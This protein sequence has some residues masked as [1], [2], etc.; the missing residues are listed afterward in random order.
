MK[1]TWTEN[2]KLSLLSLLLLAAVVSPSIATA[3]VDG[4]VDIQTEAL[5]HHEVSAEDLQFLSQLRRVLH[6]GE[7]AL[8]LMRDY[9]A[10]PRQEIEKATYEMLMTAIDP[11]RRYADPQDFISVEENQWGAILYQYSAGEDCGGEPMYEVVNRELRDSLPDSEETVLW[12]Q[13]MRFALSKLPRYEGLSFRGTRLS[14]ERIANYYRIGE[15]AKD[16]AFI[17]TSLSLDVGFRFAK[18]SAVYTEPESTDEST[19]GKVGLIMVI[20]GKTGRPISY[21]ANTYSHEQE[22]LFANGTQ[23]VVEAKSNIFWDPQFQRTQII[24]LKEI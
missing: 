11:E 13:K 12:T 3:Q 21:F 15:L 5:S 17:S 9:V 7:S 10:T 2:I 16:A 20:L 22:I 19:D 14:E 6:D 24:I 8:R 18:H 23:M 4:P 1:K